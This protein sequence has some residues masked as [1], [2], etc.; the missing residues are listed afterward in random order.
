MCAQEIIRGG[1]TT[2][3]SML[4]MILQFIPK[5]LNRRLCSLMTSILLDTSIESA[6]KYRVVSLM[7]YIIFELSFEKKIRV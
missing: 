1:R 3:M 5:I 7:Y 2:R 6:S 4:G